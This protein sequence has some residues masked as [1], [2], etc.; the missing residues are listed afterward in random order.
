MQRYAGRSAAEKLGIQERSAVALI[1]APR[2]CP[3]LLGKIPKFVEFF[4][5]NT[6]KVNV[7]LCFAQ[8]PGLLQE[9]LSQLRSCAARAKLWV[10]WRK[11]GSA[12]RGDLT[13]QLV[14]DRC[15]PARFLFPGA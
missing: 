3:K 14:R 12:A 4:E 15:N 13:E 9:R 7:I 11:G 10:L 2:D 1:D 8:N 6:E 5:H